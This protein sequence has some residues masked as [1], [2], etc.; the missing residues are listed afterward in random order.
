MINLK[1]T[2]TAYRFFEKTDNYHNKRH[3]S[4]LY[5]YI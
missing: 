5:L 1:N 2:H 4:L 3:F